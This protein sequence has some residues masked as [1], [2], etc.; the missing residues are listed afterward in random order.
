MAVAMATTSWGTCR[1]HD[2]MPPPTFH[3]NR[4]ID[5]YS[6]S[7]I[8]Q[9]GVR[10]PSRIWILLFWTTYEVNYAV[11]LHCQNLVLIRYSPPE[12]LQFY[13][14]ASLAGKCLTT[15]PFWWFLRVLNPLKIVVIQT[16]KRYMVK[17][18][19]GVRPGRSCEKSITRTGQVHKKSHKSVIFNI[20]GRK[21]PVRILQWNLAQG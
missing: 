15:P 14:F 13:N 12:I 4:C 1:G 8:L 9:Y 18:R 21:L 19:R 11:Q 2:G 17:I 7:N 6:V 10:P 16:P 3:P 20:F 5:N